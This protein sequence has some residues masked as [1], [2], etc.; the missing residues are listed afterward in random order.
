MSES[1]RTYALVTL[2]ATL[3]LCACPKKEWHYAAPPAPAPAKDFDAQFDATHLD[4]N[5][6]AQNVDWH[7]QLAGHLPNPDACNHGQPYTSACTQNQIFR[8]QPDGIHQAFCFIGKATSGSPYQSFFGHADWMVAQFNGTIG[9]FNFGDDFDYD[10]FLLPGNISAT[11]SSPHGITTNNNHVA[12]NNSNPQYIEMEFDSGETDPAF[13]TGWWN[14]FKLDGHENDPAVIPN[15]FRT[16]D[17]TL[18]CG[19]VVGLFGLDCDHGCRSELHP[20]YG[21]AIQRIE[22]PID[23][24][25]SILARNWGT[26]GYCSQYNNELA[27]Q[28]ISITLPYTSSQ[29]PTTAE[30]SG[31]AVATADS[32]AVVGCPALYFQHGQTVVNLML[33]PPEQ[34]AVA[35]FSLKLQWPD[36]AQSTACTQPRPAPAEMALAHEHAARPLDG[37]DYMGALLQAAAQN[38]NPSL[39]HPTLEKD[40]LPIAPRSQ[41]KMQSLKRIALAPQAQPCDGSISINSGPPPTKPV[42]TIHRMK[43]ELHKQVR[44]DA[45]RTYICH[46]YRTKTFTLPPGTSQQDFDRACKGVK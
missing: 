12:D 13:T 4:P 26:G 25:W 3:F 38:Q 5:G 18:T 24:E 42:P 37:E 34:Q 20:I 27:E 7:P 11:P 41:R 8:D 44:D 2:L 36:G 33:P 22:D 6:A 28:T 1:P 29:P 43:K 16:K 39:T 46:S 45:V 23:N 15:L 14:T 31:F 10:L 17:K 35:A 21:L 30:V 32:T 40:I 9:W 19:S